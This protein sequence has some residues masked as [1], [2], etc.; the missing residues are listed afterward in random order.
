MQTLIRTCIILIAALAVSGATFGLVKSGVVSSVPRGARPV[1]QLIQGAAGGAAA[2]SDQ[3]AAQS[4]AP[5][6]RAGGGRE[7][8]GGFSLFGL[9]EVLRGFLVVAV[10]VTLTSL[11]GRIRRR[12]GAAEPPIAPESSPF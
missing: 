12:R 2:P 7:G 11:A 6:P 4:G 10:I 3:H 9:A 8:R 5:G 1:E